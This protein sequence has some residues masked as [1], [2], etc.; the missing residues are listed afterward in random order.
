MI[1]EQKLKLEAWLGSIQKG[2]GDLLD[3]LLFT[4][5]VAFVTYYWMQIIKR[6]VD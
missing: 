1:N 2:E 4:G 5:L 3:W 6:L